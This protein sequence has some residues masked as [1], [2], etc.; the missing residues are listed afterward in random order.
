MQSTEDDAIKA[1]KPHNL[2]NNE[3]MCTTHIHKNTNKKRSQYLRM[4][5]SE[6]TKATLI[7]NINPI[8]TRWNEKLDQKNNKQY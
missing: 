2:Q 7:M 5:I 1:S 8:N 3:Q 6:F 4:V